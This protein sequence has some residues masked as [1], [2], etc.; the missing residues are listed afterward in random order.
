MLRI[1]LGNYKVVDVHERG[2]ACEEN[3]CQSRADYEVQRPYGWEDDAGFWLFYCAY[4]LPRE[5]QII[6]PEARQ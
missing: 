5:L 2:Y 1:Y 6:A 4:H 3:D